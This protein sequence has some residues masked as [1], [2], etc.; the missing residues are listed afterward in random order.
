MINAKFFKSG[1]LYTGFC[2]SGHS[3]SAEAG[4]DIICAFV[5]SA[6]LMAANTIT[7]V[8]KLSA[9]AEEDEGFLSLKINES[10]VAAQDILCG[11]VLHLTE[12]QKDYPKNIKVI[13]SEV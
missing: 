10:P 11:L 9:N 6:C 1:D 13:I 3:G 4:R 2:V 12:L 8:I 5:S 7:E